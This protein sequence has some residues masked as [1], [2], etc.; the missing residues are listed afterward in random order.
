MKAG[1]IILIPFPYAELTN[2][3]VRPAVVVAITDDKYKDIIVCAV[4]SVIP[5]SLSKNEIILTPDSRNRL[6][7]KSVLKVDR[8]VT[9]KHENKI[10]DLGKLSA[11]N[12][13]LFKTK[14]KRLIGK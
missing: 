10:A 9:L 4:S 8:I 14:F 1:D 11:S 2:I 3:K 6:R 7:V 5:E 12:L 13:A